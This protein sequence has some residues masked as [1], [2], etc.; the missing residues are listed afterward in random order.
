M[1]NVDLHTVIRGCLRNERYYQKKLYTAFYGFAHSIGLRYA[2]SQEEASIIM[3]KGFFNA[4]DRLNDFNKDKT[5]AFKTWL[6]FNILLAAIEHFFN[7]RQSPTIPPDSKINASNPGSDNSETLVPYED[8]INMLHQLH[9]RHRLVFNLFAI[10]GYA[11]ERI[12]AMLNISVNVSKLLVA[13][14]RENLKCLMSGLY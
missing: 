1:E 5:I 11:H 10:E 4:F 12:A 7:I 9:F 8:G 6:K 2:G 3:N 13:E 14:A